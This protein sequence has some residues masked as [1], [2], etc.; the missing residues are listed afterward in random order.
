[1]WLRLR[2]II[3]RRSYREARQRLRDAMHRLEVVRTAWHLV[4]VIEAE[5]AKGTTVA[6]IEARF[7]ALGATVEDGEL[8]VQRVRPG[9]Q[10]DDPRPPGQR[11]GRLA[12]AG[13]GFVKVLGD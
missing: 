6:E 5:R 10:R 2:G 9:R 12:S 4:E 11:A 3:G 7:R 1:M 13:S 8:G